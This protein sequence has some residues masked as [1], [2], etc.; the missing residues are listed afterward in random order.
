MDR[1][2]EIGMQELSKQRRA[3]RNA[4]TSL[5]SSDKSPFMCLAQVLELVPV[6]Q[7]TLR[8]MIANDEFPQPKHLSKRAVA[9]SRVEV[10]TWLR[11]K[12]Q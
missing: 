11:E 5:V 2:V 8:R 9:W 6:S 10:Q 4:R 12:L 7:A 1:D 3:K